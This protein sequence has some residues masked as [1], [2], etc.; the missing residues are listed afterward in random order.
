MGV[1]AT[2]ER[3]ESIGEKVTNREDQRWG[4]RD[5]PLFVRPFVRPSER[6]PLRD[7]YLS[8]EECGDADADA[9]MDAVWEAEHVRGSSNCTLKNAVTIMYIKNSNG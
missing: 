3:A 9:A 4:A 1:G 7:G 2:P 8:D 6:I 5:G